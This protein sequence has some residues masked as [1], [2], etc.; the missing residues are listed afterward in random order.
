MKRVF[1]RNSPLKVVN[2]DHRSTSMSYV[3]PKVSWDA[4]PRRVHS[5]EHGPR[6]QVYNFH[7]DM[8]RD[9]MIPDVN[10]F[11]LLSPG[12]WGHLLIECMRC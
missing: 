7:P 5:Y 8:N 9:K 1:C 4:L 3:S 12:E 11:V 2:Q 10:M 6:C